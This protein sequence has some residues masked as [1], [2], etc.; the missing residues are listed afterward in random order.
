MLLAASG[1]TESQVVISVEHLEWAQAILEYAKRGI[2]RLY[3]IMAT[4]TF[5]LHYDRIKRIIRKAGGEIPQS[6]LG[7]QLSHVLSSS[8]VKEIIQT[9]QDNREVEVTTALGRRDYNVKLL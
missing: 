7:K 5:G 3:R 2:P 1:S 6:K 4:G 9:M 8:Q